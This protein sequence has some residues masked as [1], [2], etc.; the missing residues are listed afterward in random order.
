MKIARRYKVKNKKNT[1][2]TIIQLILIICMIL[3]LYYILKWTGEN[4]KTKKLNNKV[5]RAVT[6]DSENQ[7]NVNFNE[8]EKEN[9]DIVAWIRVNNTAIDYPVVKTTNNDY[10]LYRSLDKTTNSAGWIFMDYKNKLDG[11]D[12]NIVIY[13]HNRKDGSMFGTLKKAFE[14]EW[15]LNEQNQ[16][17]EL[18]TK[19]EKCKYK[20]FSIYEVPDEDYY[21]TTNFYSNES[22]KNF[23][24]TIKSRSIYNF[25][26][27]LDETAQ[28]LTLSTCGVTNKTRVVMHAKK[29][30]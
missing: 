26:V 18:I 30:Q 8:L 21:I 4:N 29:Y 22:F 16:E 10:Y 6:I 3:S 27:E 25:N 20:I 24:S 15:Y 17:I 23:L 13:G 14:K 1:I 19:E 9:E 2:I 28:I 5:K 11:T 12:K 7:Y